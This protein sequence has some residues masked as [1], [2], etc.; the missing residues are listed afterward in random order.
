MA[1]G[2][3]RSNFCARRKSQRNKNMQNPPDVVTRTLN[4]FAIR[5]LADLRLPQGDFSEFF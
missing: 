2:Q 5:V 4:T 3:I 1:K